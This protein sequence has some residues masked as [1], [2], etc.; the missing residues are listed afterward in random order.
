MAMAANLGDCWVI[1]CLLVQRHP[2][3]EGW[4]S[5]GFERLLGQKA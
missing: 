3:V 5:A 4:V 2:C 1:P